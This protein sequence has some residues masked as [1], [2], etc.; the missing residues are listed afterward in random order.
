M[1]R[2]ILIPISLF[3]AACCCLTA[4]FWHG[5]YLPFKPCRPI[6][7]PE[8]QVITGEYSHTSSD[9]LES[10]LSF[11]DQHLNAQPAL[12]ADVGQWG[13]EILEN[14]T[15]LYS[16]YG[17]DINGLTTETGCIYITTNEGK[18]NRIKDALY[19]GEGAKQQCPR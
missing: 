16:C 15:Y 6:T 19:W 2:R 1:R 12:E 17:V 11:Y 8:G 5:Y 7:Y 4:I 3:L 18:E 9:S 13:K 14:S 10:I